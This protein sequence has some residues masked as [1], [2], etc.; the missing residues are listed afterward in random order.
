MY[1]TSL[2]VTYLPLPLHFKL[3]IMYLS[4][5]SDVPINYVYNKVPSHCQRVKVGYKRAQFNNEVTS[6][7]CKETVN[8]FTLTERRNDILNYVLFS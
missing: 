7:L 1:L 6:V 5:T 4:P 8:T 2:Q 3:C